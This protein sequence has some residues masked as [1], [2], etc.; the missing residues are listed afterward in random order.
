MPK[1]E[2][3]V[4]SVEIQ[5][6]KIPRNSFVVEKNFVLYKLIDL[7]NIA[8]ITEDTEK[9][10]LY[11]V[12]VVNTKSGGILFITKIEEINKNKPINLLADDNSFFLT[13]TS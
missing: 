2:R 4:N 1:N 11:H 5:D 12:Y 13:Y 7:N 8:L 6:D 9:E 10:A 3:I